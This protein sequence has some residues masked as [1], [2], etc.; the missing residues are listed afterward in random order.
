M[1]RTDDQLKVF[2]TIAQTA[3][4]STEQTNKYE[5]KIPLEFDLQQANAKGE[6]AGKIVLSYQI[7]ENNREVINLPF[8]TKIKSGWPL[9]LIFILLGTAV[10][11][12]LSW[13][14]AKGR[15]RDE[16][17]VRVGRLE[18]FIGKDPKFD[19]SRGFKSQIG[20]QLNNVRSAI[21]EAVSYTHLTL[22]TIYAV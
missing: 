17:L 16:I 9:P 1:Y 20:F 19:R 22:P 21:Q 2:P 11:M 15:P 6:F 13:Y 10:G 12:G 7:D 8:T 14:R 5:Y 3:D 4:L 18:T